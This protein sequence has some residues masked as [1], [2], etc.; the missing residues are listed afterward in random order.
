[1]YRVFSA[2][3]A[4]VALA[5]LSPDAL[6]GLAVERFGGQASAYDRVMPGD[7]ELFD[8]ERAAIHD[9]FP[10][11]PARLLVGGVGAGRE[12]LALATLGYWVVGFEPSAALC[13]ILVRRARKAGLAAV[14]VV[15]ASYE[16][17]VEAVRAAQGRQP[18]PEGLGRIM[19]AA[20]YDGVIVGWGSIGCIASAETREALLSAAKALCP[21]GPALASFTRHV[22]GRGGA[23]RAAAL[24]RRFL[25]WFPSGRPVDPGDRLEWFGFE[26]AFTD[27][28]VDYLVSR[29]GYRMVRRAH[30]PHFHVVL[31][32]Q[33][34]GATLQTGDDDLREV[35]AGSSRHGI[36]PWRGPMSPDAAP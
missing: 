30:E 13:E 12:V 27:D 2:V 7:Q 26:H 32:P 1:M 25:G 5:R 34:N 16:A 9:F 35:R 20:P 6:S 29:A 23:A 11:P 4:E 3:R 10:P 36:I 24:A 8:W 33:A 22:P 21:A 18:V 17:V 31:V 15:Q 28:E 19:G 14:D